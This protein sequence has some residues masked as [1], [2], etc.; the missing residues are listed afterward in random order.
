MLASRIAA[1]F[2]GLVLSGASRLANEDSRQIRRIV[3]VLFTH[4]SCGTW[5]C[6]ATG[7]HPQTFTAL[8]PPHLS[9][10]GLF[11]PS[12]SPNI[13]RGM[14]VTVVVA[15]PSGGPRV[16]SAAIHPNRTS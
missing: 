4:T 16:C 5:E 1:C 3:H 12:G 6:W 10:V 7:A 14:P 11:A 13:L 2:D 8:N 15:A 9:V